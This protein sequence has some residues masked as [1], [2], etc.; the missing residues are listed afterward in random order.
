MNVEPL[1]GYA[2]LKTEVEA[3]MHPMSTPLMM[4]TRSEAKPGVVVKQN[5]CPVMPGTKVLYKPGVGYHV[6]TSD[7]GAYLLVNC[8]D[9]MAF[10]TE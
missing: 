6:K 2:I 9:I 5:N 4:Y 7:D 8:K 1:E 10:V 3:S